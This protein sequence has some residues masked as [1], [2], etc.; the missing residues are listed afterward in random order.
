MKKPDPHYVPCAWILYQEGG[1]HDL[2]NTHE[3]WVQKE[4]IVCVQQ[5]HCLLFGAVIMPT[6]FH[7]L[8]LGV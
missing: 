4:A 6:Y 5:Q 8:Q 1:Q 2:K 3:N 7:V